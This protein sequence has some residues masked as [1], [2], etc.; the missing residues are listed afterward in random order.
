MITA[1]AA[2]VSV[3]ASTPA[4]N[5]ESRAWSFLLSSEPHSQSFIWMAGAIGSACAVLGLMLL[6]ADATPRLMWPLAATGQLAL[7]IYVGHI[8]AMH[9]SGDL[10]EREQVAG[11]AI[12]VAIFMAVTITFS[13]TY[14]AAFKR[15]PLEAIL[16]LPYNAALATHRRVAVNKQGRDGPL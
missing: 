16:S 8:V 13:V 2:S 7:T 5:P 15:G 4:L 1:V 9:L 11:A 3:L 12:I 6:A 14:R 10:L